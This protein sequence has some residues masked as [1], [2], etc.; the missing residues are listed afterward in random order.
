MITIPANPINIADHLFIPTCS[1]KKITDKIVAKIGTVN[2]SDVA[3]GRETRL[4]PVNMHSMHTPPTLPL[5]TCNFTEDVFTVSSP[6]HSR[7][8]KRIINTNDAL[9]RVITKGCKE[10]LRTFT[11]ACIRTIESPPIIIKRIALINKAR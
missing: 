11:D 3:S 4:K 7:T 5:I 10:A 2:K 6:F 1:D 8:G 9:K